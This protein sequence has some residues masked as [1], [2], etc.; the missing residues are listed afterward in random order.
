MVIIFLS[1]VCCRSPIIPARPTYSA[2][3]LNSLQNDD[4]PGVPNV[5]TNPN[6]PETDVNKNGNLSKP[7]SNGMPSKV[8]KELD[9]RING[10]F[11]NI[12]EAYRDKSNHRRYNSWDNGN[13]MDPSEQNVSPIE[14]SQ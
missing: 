3:M 7:Q 9:K 12:A 8:L 13:P 6:L 14:I 11:S 2:E 10:S 1:R 5:W 4:L